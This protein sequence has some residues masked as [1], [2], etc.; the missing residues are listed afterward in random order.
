MNFISDS[1]CNFFLF[2]FFFRFWVMKIVSSLLGWGWK[3]LELSIWERKIIIIVILSKPVELL[4]FFYQALVLANFA[5]GVV[6]QF[7]VHFFVL[8]S[9]LLFSFYS[10][11]IICF[12]KKI[13]EDRILRSLYSWRKI[14]NSIFE[15]HSFIKKELHKY[16]HLLDNF[17]IFTFF[18][19]F[20]C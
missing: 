9:F 10:N 2:L 7:C 4:H 18:S 13:L 14:Y 6:L 12:L 17:D 16:L 15:L 8:L 3:S 1:A 19:N 11:F 5:L 20:T